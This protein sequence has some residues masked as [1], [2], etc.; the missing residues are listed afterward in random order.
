LRDSAVEQF[1]LLLVQSKFDD[2]L[3]HESFPCIGGQIA[4]SRIQDMAI[5][6]G[7][8]AGQASPLR[9]SRGSG[10][11]TRPAFMLV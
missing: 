3:G 9:P 1:Q 6:G 2:R 10:G 4:K 7:S 8:C 5:D 11:V